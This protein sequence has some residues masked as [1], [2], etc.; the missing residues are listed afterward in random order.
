M[1]SKTVLNGLKPSYLE[2]LVP[3]MCPKKMGS[4]GLS[5]GTVAI[6]LCWYKPSKV[7]TLV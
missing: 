2:G 1:T 7:P 4:T 3:K 6:R 5:L